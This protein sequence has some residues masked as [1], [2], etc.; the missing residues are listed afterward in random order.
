V[1]TAVGCIFIDE[2]RQFYLQHLKKYC[3][4]HDV[5]VL[6]Y[7]LMTNHVHLIL[8]PEKEDSLQCVLNVLKLLHMR[9]A[10]YINR[11]HQWSGHLC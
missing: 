3:Q 6:A 4:L 7:C 1:V 10:Q 11:Q 5:K 9:Y 2:D 8:I